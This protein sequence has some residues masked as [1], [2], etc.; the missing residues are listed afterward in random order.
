MLFAFLYGL[1]IENTKYETNDTLKYNLMDSEFHYT[2]YTDTTSAQAKC[3]TY[4]DSIKIN[5]APLE[6][7]G[8]LFYSKDATFEYDSASGT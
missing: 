1:Y 5:Y 3:Y 8:K 4:S 7:K 6:F 2:A